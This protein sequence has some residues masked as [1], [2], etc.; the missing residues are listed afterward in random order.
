MSM[1]I[2]RRAAL[3]LPMALA[4]TAAVS[5]RPAIGHEG[6]DDEGAAPASA[7]PRVSADSEQF[8]LVGIL[9]EGGTLTIYLDRAA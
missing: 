7:A 4:L 9:G 5:G 6:H 8:E 3:V 2:S 1:R